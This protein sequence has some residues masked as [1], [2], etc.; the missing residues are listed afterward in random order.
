MADTGAA[1]A[2][3]LQ[4]APKASQGSSSELRSH[5]TPELVFAL[6]GPI[7]SP[8]REVA[9]ALQKLLKEGFDYDVEVVRL[10]AFIEQL[11]GIQTPTAAFDRARDLIERGNN[12]R[13]KHGASIL[14]DMAISEIAL[15]REQRD[16]DAGGAFR[17]ARV[18]HIIDSIKNEAELVALRLVYRD[19][20]HCIGVFASVQERERRL[21]NSGMTAPQLHQLMDQDSGEEISHGQTVRD[22]FPR[23]DYFLRSPPDAKGVI[24]SRLQRYLNLVFSTEVITP[25]TAETAMYQATSAARNSACLS[26]QVGACVV[27]ETGQILSIGWN[28]VPRFGGGL[29]VEDGDPANDKRCARWGG[30]CYNDDE[31]QGIAAEVAEAL[32]KAGLLQ[33]D[34]AEAARTIL[35]SNVGKLIEFSRAIHAEMHAVLLAS[36]TA[37]SRVKGS[38]LY[39]TTYPCHYCARHLVAAGIVA[40]YYIE[41]YRKSLAAKLHD[42]AITEIEGVTGKVKIIPYDGVAPNKYLE[43]F[44]MKA[45]QRKVAGQLK[46]SSPSVATPKSEVTLESVPTLEG[47]VVRRLREQ[48]LLGGQNPTGEAS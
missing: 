33:G 26:R 32:S 5:H 2:K 13:A 16:R 19:M 29:Y 18:C 25:T 44:G 31:K 22:T 28:D 35:K 3:A 48:S 8:L 42:D 10:S 14:A 27:D 46:G 30:K 24:E 47:L 20:L 39:C 36:Q 21:T 11:D 43:L 7:G 37:G 41:P 45:D 4:Q 17:P 15:R 40:V 34:K 1:R 12:L 23:S 38:V 9:A 6:C